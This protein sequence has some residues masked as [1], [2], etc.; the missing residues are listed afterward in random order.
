MPWYLQHSLAGL[1]QP[2]LYRKRNKTLLSEQQLEELREVVEQETMA[3]YEP[4]A[5]HVHQ[6]FLEAYSHLREQARM[7]ML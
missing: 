1:E 5:A 7:C 4:G 2:S 3:S 6:G